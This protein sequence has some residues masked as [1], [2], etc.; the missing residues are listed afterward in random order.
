[1]LY[2]VLLGQLD[3]SLR[4]NDMLF[5][6]NMGKEQLHKISLTASFLS[7]QNMKNMR[8]ITLI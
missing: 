2:D 7:R 1:M 6:T 3:S 5:H 4:W 8:T